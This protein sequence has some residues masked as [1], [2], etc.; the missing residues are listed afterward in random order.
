MKIGP[1]QMMMMSSIRA[2]QCEESKLSVFF[3]QSF[4]HKFKIFRKL[5]CSI[6]CIVSNKL[7]VIRPFDCAALRVATGPGTSRKCTSLARSPDFSSFIVERF[8]G[9]TGGPSGPSVRPDQ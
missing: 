7:I 1:N 6:L 8:S 3:R 9:R 2:K 5:L 4:V